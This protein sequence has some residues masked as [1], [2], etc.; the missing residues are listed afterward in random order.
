[1]KGQTTP[2]AVLVVMYKE[3][4]GVQIDEIFDVSISNIVLRLRSAFIV[5]NTPFESIKIMCFIPLNVQVVRCL[6]SFMLKG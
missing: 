5:K 3:L 2:I 1:M 6:I 4:I